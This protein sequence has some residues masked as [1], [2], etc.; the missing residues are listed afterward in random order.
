MRLYMIRHGQSTAN[1][2]RLHAGWAQIPLTEQ[3]FADARFAGT[4]LEGLSFDKVYVSDL[5]RAIQT[6]ET[7]L[8]GVEGERTHLLRETHVGSLS[9]KDPDQCFALYGQQYITDKAARDYTRYGGENMAMHHQRIVEFADLLARDPV[10][11][12]AAFTHEG[13]IRCMLNIAL[14]HPHKKEDYPL[15]NGSVTVFSYENGTWKLDRLTE[16]ESICS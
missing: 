1:A 15:A 13:S 6:L 8:P 14:G 9:G 16:G 2:G 4:Q 11:A 3:G 10:D 7:A 5:L 12:V